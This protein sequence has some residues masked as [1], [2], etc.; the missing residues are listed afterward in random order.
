MLAS[1]QYTF[2]LKYAWEKHIGK[3][4]LSKYLES[5]TLKYLGNSL[6]EHM[7]A[8]FTESRPF[9]NSLLIISSCCLFID[10]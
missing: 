6:S 10:C 8:L 5:Y 2:L 9:A 3:E 1:H 7:T 4:R